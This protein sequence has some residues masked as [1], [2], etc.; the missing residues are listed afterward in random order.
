MGAYFPV[1]RVSTAEMNAY[2]SLSDETKSLIV[3]ILESKKITPP[4]ASTW[5]ATF[6]T[7]GS[8]LYGK[9][10]T[11]SFIYDYKSAFDRL[12]EINENLTDENGNN[13]VTHCS[14]KMNDAGLNFIP[15]VHFD[16][17][18]WYINSVVALRKDSLAIRVR[19]HDFSSTLDEIMLQTVNQ[20]ILERFNE[21][22]PRTY[23]ILD[24]YN[25]PTSE[26]RIL[27]AINTF[28]RVDGCELV[29]SLTNCPEDA[30]V[31]GPMTFGFAAARD[32]LRVFNS[33]SNTFQNLHFSDYTVRVNA[34]PDREARIDYYNTY[35][36]IFYTSEDSYMIGKSSLIKDNGIDNFHSICKEIVDSDV[37]AGETFS[38][39]D[40]A[41]Y[42]CSERKLHMSDH[43]KPIEYGVNHHI[44][45]TS[46]QL[47]QN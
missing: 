28:S 34:E 25:V 21:F 18:N 3:P 17:P 2:G 35:I 20:N 27:N 9:F 10:S 16:S 7:L 30:S 46:T 22:S 31:V 42:R 8:Y 40:N 6:N 38:A 4:R 12:G 11:H 32:D 37:Y 44:Q 14:Q 15:C 43:S 19:C 36:K 29:L 47:R 45:L 13:L 33:L 1:L 5:W 26:E 41:I 24:F 23:I 39:G